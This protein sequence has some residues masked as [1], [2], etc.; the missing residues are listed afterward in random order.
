MCEPPQRQLGKHANLRKHAKESRSEGQVFKHLS[1]AKL[2][3]LTPPTH[4]AHAFDSL[5]C[6]I[7]GPFL[8]SCGVPPMLDASIYSW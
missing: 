2:Q 8:D 3:T 4:A 1:L 7:E 6:Q 5:A